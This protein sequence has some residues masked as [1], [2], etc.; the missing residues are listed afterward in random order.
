MKASIKKNSEVKFIANPHSYFIEEGWR[1]IAPEYLKFPE[2]VDPYS[3]INSANS[4]MLKLKI[5]NLRQIALLLNTRRDVP[6][7]TS[8]QEF[9]FDECT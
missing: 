1:A 8:L 6:D 9:G 3:L 5:R 4:K 7:R 2:M